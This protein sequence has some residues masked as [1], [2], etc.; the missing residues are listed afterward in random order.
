[1]TD[2]E[3]CCTYQCE[4]GKNCPVRATRRVR[5]GQPAPPLL[6]DPEH[7]EKEEEL[8]DW[9]SALIVVAIIVVVGLF[10]L[11]WVSVL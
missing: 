5:A 10:A 6:L 11:G 2:N 4:Q 8:P 9:M 3:D 1:M 7:Y